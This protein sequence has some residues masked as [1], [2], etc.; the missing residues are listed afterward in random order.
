MEPRDGQS[1]VQSR[2]RIIQYLYHCL[3]NVGCDTLMFFTSSHYLLWLA[4]FCF[5]NG[6]F[7]AANFMQFSRKRDDIERGQ[8]LVAGICSSVAT[9]N[10]ITIT[11]IWNH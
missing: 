7:G 6:F 1:A 10:L 8:A 9:I 3:R 11:A 2:G 5:W 4:L